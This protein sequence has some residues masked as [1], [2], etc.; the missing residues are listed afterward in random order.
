[1]VLRE[2]RSRYT[3]LVPDD[4]V[5]DQ[6][7]RAV[8]DLLGSINV[9]ALPEMA[10]RLVTVR[11]DQHLTDTNPPAEQQACPAGVGDR[12]RGPYLIG[13]CDRVAELFLRKSDHSNTAP[14]WA[15]GWEAPARAGGAIGSGRQRWR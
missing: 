4:V 11:L 15:S 12:E 14:L 6:M 10:S 2:L 3:G 13:E 5:R 8:R 7:Q 9:E 1:M